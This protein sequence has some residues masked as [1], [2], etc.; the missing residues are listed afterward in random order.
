MTFRRGALREG[1]SGPSAALRRSR[2][3]RPDH[4]KHRRQDH[5]FLRRSAS[6]RDG[7]GHEPESPGHADER[8]AAGRL[9]SLSGGGPRRLCPEGA[10]R[11]LSPRG[12]DRH[13]LAR[14]DR[15]RQ[16]G[17]AAC[18]RG[19]GR[20]LGPGPAHR[21]DLDDDRHQ[22][23]EQRDRAAPGGPQLR[24]HRAR[25]SRCRHGPRGHG[26]ALAR[27]DDLR[28][29]LGREPVDHRR[30]QHHQR[31]QGNS[32]Q[33]HQ[34]RVRSGGRGQ[35]RRLSGRI[36]PGARG[37]HQR[38]H[39]VRRKRLPRRRLRLLRLGG[40]HG[41]AAVPA[42]RRRASRRCASSTGNGSTTASTSAGSSSR[43][44]CGSSAPTTAS[45]FRATC[46][47]WTTPPMS[48]RA[49]GSR[50]TRRAT[51]IPES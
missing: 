27:A 48:R 19:A 15:D 36:W 23:H 22:L 50:S 37:R 14:C 17:P 12:E 47:G 11:R 18:R 7:R 3:P 16:H 20:R 24:R 9:L 38:R 44:G 41:G 5:R 39:E 26:G 21:Y 29:H 32:G 40:D 31:L 28:G 4:G 43:I 51:S 6:R 33:G 49:I 42:G 8:H 46:R 30:R 34:Q 45:V 35:D 1:A 2:G 13:G 10:P 25:E